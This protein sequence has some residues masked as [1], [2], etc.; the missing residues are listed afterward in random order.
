MFPLASA[1]GP[2]PAIQKAPREPFG[3][4]FN[5]LRSVSVLASND[6]IQPVYGSI[7]QCEVQAVTT[8][9]LRSSNAARSSYCL[10]SKVNTP[11]ALPAPDPVNVA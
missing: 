2:S 8:V 7:S 9:P 11:P 10:G 5:T 4:T 1:A 6:M 3:V